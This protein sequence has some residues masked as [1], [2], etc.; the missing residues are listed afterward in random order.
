MQVVALGV[1]FSRSSDSS[2]TISS[3]AIVRANESA[4][5]PGIGTGAIVIVFY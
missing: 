4:S 5:N 1:F 3:G 2:A